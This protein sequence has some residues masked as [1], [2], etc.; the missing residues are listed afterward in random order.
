MAAAGTL[1]LG[2]DMALF[3][4]KQT[5]NQA[6]LAGKES[7]PKE[8]LLPLS[9][10]FK[11][12]LHPMS[13]SGTGNLSTERAPHVKT[14][15]ESSSTLIYNNEK[16]TKGKRF[17]SSDLTCQNETSPLEH[18]ISMEDSQGN[19]D[20]SFS[21]KP[22]EECSKRP[23]PVSVPVN[24][25][26]LRQN[27]PSQEVSSVSTAGESGSPIKPQHYQEPM[28]WVPSGMNWCIDEIGDE[29]I[30]IDKV[31][32]RQIEWSRTYVPVNW[33]IEAKKIPVQKSKNGEYWNIRDLGNKVAYFDGKPCRSVT[34]YPT[35]EPEENIVDTEDV[36]AEEK[37]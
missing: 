21:E 30:T 9:S 29:T 27:S 17:V 2:S 5:G 15:E 10:L 24:T 19:S 12:A 31:A 14:I 8:E 26:T 11:E 20:H 34:W 35:L 33:I 3:T 18:G 16:S 22:T 7:S 6:D 37:A 36:P 28:V 23:K 1:L 32:F 13:E 4:S 25:T